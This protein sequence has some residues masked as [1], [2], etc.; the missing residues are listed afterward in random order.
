MEWGGGK[1]LIFIITLFYLYILR[2]NKIDDHTVNDYT[3]NRGAFYDRYKT[4]N[5]P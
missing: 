4:R 5:N 3:E 1:L 2:N